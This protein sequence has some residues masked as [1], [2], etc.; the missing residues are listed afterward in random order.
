HRRTAFSRNQ[1]K[2]ACGDRMNAVAGKAVNRTNAWARL[3][4]SSLAAVGGFA[5]AQAGELQHAA[6]VIGTVLLAAIRP[7]H[8]SRPVRNAFA[9]Q[10]LRFFHL[11]VLRTDLSTRDTQCVI[12]TTL[13]IVQRY[14]HRLF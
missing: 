9:R 4:L 13:P 5:R 12:S 14:R 10:L 3:P 8:W 2:F 7:K 6:T 11:Q 1:Q